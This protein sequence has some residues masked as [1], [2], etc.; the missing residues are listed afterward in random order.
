MNWQLH[1][2]LRPGVVLA[3][4]VLLGWFVLKVHAALTPFILGFILAYVLDPFV[5]ELEK[6]RIPRSL[7]ILLLYLLAAAA[8]GLSIYYILPVFLRDLNSLM[9]LIPEYTRQVQATLLDMQLGYNRVPIPEGVR[10]VI[11]ETI[12]WGEEATLGMIRGVAEAL[13]WLFSQSFN[14]ILAPILSFYFL[15]EFNTLGPLLL[16]FLPA[17]LRPEVSQIVTE[18]NLVLKRFIRGNLLVALFVGVITTI[19]M[20][21]IGMDFPL[22]IG[23]M[24]GVTN[25]I[26][27]F[28]AIISAVPALLL[29]LLKSKWLAL[30]V[31]GMMFL[32]QQLEGNILSPRIL[33]QSVG[34]HPLLIILALLVA[35]QLWG[36]MGLLLAVP[37]AGVLKVLLKHLYL[38]LV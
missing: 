23:M 30:Y 10:Q 38:K 17:R 3:A 28:G 27:Y 7:A 24:V 33:G 29:A 18:I 25:F 2:F 31:L 26:P 32:V 36:I 4:L 34:L 9:E 11:D 16:G 22:L 5:D 12:K 20:I 21:L 8:V 19:G 35:G 13:I 15:M 14:L 1:R 37:L 6:Y